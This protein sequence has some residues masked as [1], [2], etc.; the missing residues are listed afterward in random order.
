MGRVLG[1][2]VLSY[3]PCDQRPLPRHTATVSRRSRALLLLL[4]LSLELTFAAPRQRIRRKPGT[5]PKERL[6][7]QTKIKNSCAE[8]FGCEEHLKCC[9]FACGKKCMDPY[10]EPCMLSLD[11]GNC[12]RFDRR[13]YYDLKNLLCKPFKYGGCDGNSNNF[14][15]K[16]DCMK[17]CSLTVKKGQCPLFPSKNRMECSGSCKSDNDCADKEKCCESMCGFVCSVAWVVKTGSCPQKPPTC[18]RIDKP[19]CQRDEDCQ[20]GEKCCSRCGLKCLE[21]R[22]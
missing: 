9:Q 10:E 4:S 3:L 7:C 15:S 2:K 20:L 12:D 6:K 11:Q 16:E 1:L 14:L 22:A 17:A 13:W 8:D 5:C 18:L 19:K 21:P